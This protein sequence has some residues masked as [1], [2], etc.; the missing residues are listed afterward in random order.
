[1][2]LLKIIYS[3]KGY[4]VLLKVFENIL[5]IVMNYLGAFDFRVG[6]FDRVSQLDVL[7][8]IVKAIFF[9]LLQVIDLGF[10]R[11]LLWLIEFSSI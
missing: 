6:A 9:W 4:I 1:M 11:V 5:S 3:M 2:K 10:K 8:Q 7:D